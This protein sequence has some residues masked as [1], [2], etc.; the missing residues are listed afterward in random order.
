M[1]HISRPFSSPRTLHIWSPRNSLSS[2]PRCPLNPSDIPLQ[3]RRPVAHAVP[4]TPQLPFVLIFLGSRS[5]CGLLSLQV[6]WNPNNQ[7]YEYYR[8]WRTL[9]SNGCAEVTGNWPYQLDSIKA[10]VL[11]DPAPRQTKKYVKWMG[12]V[13]R[14]RRPFTIKDTST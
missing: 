3:P 4:A 9:A 1:R 5:G 6:L 12:K 8:Y 11:R 7:G 2:A 10:W 14:E 13:L